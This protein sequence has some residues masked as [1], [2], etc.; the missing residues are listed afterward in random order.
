MWHGGRKGKKRKTVWKWLFYL[1]ITKFIPQRYKLGDLLPGNL[2]RPEQK[3]GKR[4]SATADVS[5]A[6]WKPSTFLALGIYQGTRQTKVLD[7]VRLTV[8]SRDGFCCLVARLC[9]TLFDSMDCSPSGSSVH[10]ILQARMLEWVAISFSRGSFQ[11][12]IELASP[13]LWV[14]SLPLSQQGSP[15]DI[16]R[17]ICVCVCVCVCDFRKIKSRRRDCNLSKILKK[18]RVIVHISGE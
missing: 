16:D 7:H 14:D 17:Y 13:A 1:Y 2:S 3:M 11:P 6:L 10:G 9:P 15:I 4:I 12:K 18:V 8:C 5:W